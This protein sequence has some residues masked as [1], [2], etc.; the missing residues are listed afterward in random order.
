LF[1]GSNKRGEAGFMFLKVPIGARETALGTTGLT[2]TS[3]ASA[4]FWN[5]ANIASADRMTATFSHLTYFAGISSNYGAI[6]FPVSEIG[7]FAVSFNYMSYGSIGI[8][9]EAL[10]EGTG[11][12]YSPYEIALGFSYSKQITDRVSGGLTL[13]SVTSQIDRVSASNMVFDF[14][15]S[16]LTDFR[17]LKL[18]FA[19]TNLGT[20]AVY[21]GPGLNKTSTVNAANGGSATLRYGSEPF[22]MPSSVSF[23]ATMDIM[24]DET[25]AVTGVVEQNVNSFQA[26]RSNFGVEYGFKK[27]FFAR[28]GYTGTLQKASAAQD[29]HTGSNSTA[30]LTWGLGIDYKFNDKVGA[31]VDYGYMNYGPLGNTHRFSVGLKF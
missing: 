27:M 15:F 25:N 7:T 30:G 13:K 21:S 2:G 1:A 31:T 16:Y 6:A 23:G 3:G 14:G 8:T 12:N 22:E 17:G 4:I 26:S 24:R 28:L 11:A 19:I 9:T 5:P 29:Y 20:Q 10:P 18:G